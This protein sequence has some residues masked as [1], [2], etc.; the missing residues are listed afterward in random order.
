[1]NT[2]L[3]KNGSI[4]PPVGLGSF[5][6]Q[7]EE[8]AFVV[9]E[10]VKA[11]YKLIDT[12]DDYEGE[13]GIGL[14]VSNLIDEG[15]CKREDIFLQTKVSNNDSY[16]DEPLRAIYFTEYSPYMKRH[17]IDSIVREKVETSLR[18]MRTDYLDS[19]LIHFPYEPYYV[20]I[21]KTLIKMKEEG[22]V[23]YIGVSNFHPRHI[24][25]LIAETGV[26]PTMNEIYLSPIGSKENQVQYANENDIILMTYSP[27]MDLTS[28]RFSTELFQSMREKYN[29]TDAQLILRWNIQ[30]GS[31]PLPKSSNPN[32]LKQNIDVLDF[33]LTQ[34]EVSLISSLNRDYQ[35]LPESLNCPGI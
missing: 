34:E 28:K 31:I 7:N 10:C 9:K 26:K 6:L 23:R 27:L 2:L 29:K 5:P 17:S 11:G 1:M 21:W 30:R 13:M 12:S 35:Y 32:R 24:E 3:T 18:E 14:G 19:V 4:V 8:M 33:S 25:H 15:F 22:M 16:N 20:E